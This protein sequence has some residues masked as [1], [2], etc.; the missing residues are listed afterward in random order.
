MYRQV[1]YASSKALA[2]P[3]MGSNA[4][5]NAPVLS[6]GRFLAD[7]RVPRPRADSNAL[8]AAAAFGLFSHFTDTGYHTVD[9]DPL[10]G[11][12]G[13]IVEGDP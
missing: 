5:R 11:G 7:T 13:E 4:R 9:A 2:H 6:V 12:N 8:I 3:R 10:T 1:L